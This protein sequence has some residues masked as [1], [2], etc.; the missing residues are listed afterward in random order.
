MLPK[1]GDGNNQEIAYQNTS[2]NTNLKMEAKIIIRRYSYILLK[3]SIG[4]IANK[5]LLLAETQQ[6]QRNSSS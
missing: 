6:W 4:E 2:V 5:E 3:D 1:M